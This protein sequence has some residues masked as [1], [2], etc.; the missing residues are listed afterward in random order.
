MSTCLI[1]VSQEPGLSCKLSQLAK[2][3][4]EPASIADNGEVCMVQSASITVP[5]HIF[6]KGI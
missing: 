2:R 1:V 3:V 6:L 5:A 4:F